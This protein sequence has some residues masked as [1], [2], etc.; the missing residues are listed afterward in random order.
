MVSCTLV[1]VEFYFGGIGMRST[2]ELLTQKKVP[3]GKSIVYCFEPIS[4][5]TNTESFDFLGVTNPV[6]VPKQ[7]GV[8][9]STL[10]SGLQGPGFISQWGRNFL[11]QK[12]SAIKLQTKTRHK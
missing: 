11:L 9:V 5:F 8:M 4:L 2:F 3:T 1:F 10:C 12:G 6:L 7:G